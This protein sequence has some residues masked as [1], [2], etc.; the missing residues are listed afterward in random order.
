MCVFICVS[1]THV[2]NIKKETPN[3]SLGQAVSFTIK[4]QYSSVQRASFVE[5]TNKILDKNRVWIPKL[6]ILD[7]LTIKC[8]PIFEKLF[9]CNSIAVEQRLYANTYIY[10]AQC[11]WR[12]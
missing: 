3:I 7:L 10:I 11:I 4:T 1:T 5:R 12:L 9:N 2:F 8:I 6:K